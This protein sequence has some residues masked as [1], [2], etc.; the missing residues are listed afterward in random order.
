MVVTSECLGLVACLPFSLCFLQ[1]D[2]YVLF[3]Q[4]EIVAESLQIGYFSWGRTCQGNLPPQTAYPRMMGWLVS[5]GRRPPDL[6]NAWLNWIVGVRSQTGQPPHSTSVFKRPPSGAPW[7]GSCSRGLTGPQDEG[8]FLLVFPQSH[9]GGPRMT[10]RGNAN[11]CGHAILF[12][13]SKH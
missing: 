3:K 11:N 2:A 5:Q 10:C 13:G 1:F 9:H 12:I 4:S 8:S 6:K 7:C